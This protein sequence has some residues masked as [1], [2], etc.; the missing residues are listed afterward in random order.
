[1]KTIYLIH[2][3]DGSPKEPM[4]QW[5]KTQLEQKG[6]TV[7]I[8]KMPD[9]E[10]PKIET[11]IPFLTEIILNLDENSYLIGHSVGCQAVLRFM[12]TLPEEIKLSGVILIAPWMHLDEQTIK[13]EGEEI[14]E[15]A[16]P[17]ME[18]P[19][20][21]KKVKS[22]TNNFTCLLS[23][24]DPYVPLSNKELFEKSLNAKIIIEKNKGHYTEDDSIIENQTVIDL[25]R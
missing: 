9:P 13:D 20:D 7:I 21:W 1:M 6:Y 16:K 17:W 23:D 8:P 18:T 3:W 11:W 25:I 2:G 10:V 24:N 22:H 5:I 4:H 19:I 15:I 12:E 14:V